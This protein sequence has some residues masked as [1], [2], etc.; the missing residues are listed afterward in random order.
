MLR[1]AA[2]G[3]LICRLPPGLIEPLIQRLEVLKISLPLLEGQKHVVQ[4]H[5]S[6]PPYEELSPVVMVLAAQELRTRTVDRRHK[7]RG[8]KMIENELQSNLAPPRI[9]LINDRIRR[10]PSKRPC[11]LVDTHAELAIS[12][13]VDPTSKTAAETTKADVDSPGSDRLR[14]SQIRFETVSKIGIA[15]DLIE[16][17]LTTS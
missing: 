9:A 4:E 15:N 14:E 12:F 1:Q 8:V 7:P 3:G 6:D 17:G 2:L 5:L 10:T 11:F 13:A 16:P